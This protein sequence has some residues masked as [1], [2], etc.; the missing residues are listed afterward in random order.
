[1]LTNHMRTT[2]G[3]LVLLSS[4]ECSMC[5]MNEAGVTR[6]HGII[7]LEELNQHQ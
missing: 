2:T 3:F 7:E 4:M 6:L 1:M 5:F